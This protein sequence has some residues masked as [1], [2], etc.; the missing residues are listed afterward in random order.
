MNAELLLTGITGN[1]G[2]AVAQR[3]SVLNIRFKALSRNESDIEGLVVA[4]LL[5][6]A[7]LVEALKNMKQVFLVTPH[8]PND[9][10][11]E[12][13]MGIN[14]INAA[15]KTGVEHIVFNSVASAD[16]QTGIPH[17]ESKYK[18][19]QYLQE[20][21]LNWTIIRPVAF[22]DTLLPE[23]LK[24]ML[25]DNVLKL[26]MSDEVNLQTVA[27]KDIA[28]FS[29]QALL[30]PEKYKNRIIEIAGDTQTLN[31]MLKTINN[32]MKKPIT[33][34]QITP[35]ESLKLLGE[36]FTKMFCWF[37]EKGYQVD[38]KKLSKEFN[39]SMTNFEE[40]LSDIAR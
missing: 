29:S 1:Q 5:D 15:T 4:D 37:N 17:F 25:Q 33:F 10:D 8:L 18:I 9:P 7:S 39:I 40:L 36:D 31:S 34:N 12:F 23:N 21:G 3:L 14:M 13:Q 32:Y 26:P 20:S 2:K 16:Q 28:W 19:E 6:P 11:T 30:N 27:L 24:Y 22:M 38:I 35:N